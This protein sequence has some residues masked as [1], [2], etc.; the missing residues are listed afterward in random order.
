MTRR[1]LFLWPA[2]ILLMGAMD[3]PPGL[4]FGGFAPAIRAEV[5]AVR[6]SA[7]SVEITW[8]TDLGADSLIVERATPGGLFVPLTRARDSRASLRDTLAA[9]STACFRLASALGDRTPGP[10]TCVEPTPSMVQIEVEP[11]PA[12]A[13]IRWQTAEVVDS[14]AVWRA[15]AAAPR[16]H[17]SARR[18]A[19]VA[20]TDTS[21]LDSTAAAGDDRLEYWVVPFA[22]GHW[23]RPS[24]PVSVS[25]AST[26][27]PEPALNTTLIPPSLLARALPESHS[28]TAHRLPVPQV[29]ARG[30]ARMEVWAETSETLRVERR[31]SGRGAVFSPIGR[32]MPGGILVDEDPL[33]SPELQVEYR[34]A[35]LSEQERA[36]PACPPIRPLHVPP[37]IQSLVSITDRSVRV[38]FRA[39]DPSADSLRLLRRRLPGTGGSAGLAMGTRVQT[40]PQRLSFADL[41]AAPDQPEERIAELDARDTLW[42]DQGLELG[43]RVTYRIESF[44]DGKRLAQAMSPQAVTLM[45]GPPSSLAARIG[46]GSSV[47]LNWRDDCTYET[48]YVVYRDG[49]GGM[50]EAAKLP[51]NASAWVD[52]SLIG[53]GPWRYAVATLAQTGRSARCEAVVVAVDVYPASDLRGRLESIDHVV[54]H[55]TPPKGTITGYEL[56]RRVGLSLPFAAIDTLPP[57]QTSFDDRDFRPGEDHRYRLRTLGLTH[58]SGPSKSWLA[59]LP[60]PFVGGISTHLPSGE[61]AWVARRAVTRAE[62][63]LYAASAAATTPESWGTLWE[64]ATDDDWP[65]TDLSWIEAARYLDWVS[66]LFGLEPYYGGGEGSGHETG[67]VRLPSSALW[68]VAVLGSVAGSARIGTSGAVNEGPGELDDTALFGV[69]STRPAI[70][71]TQGDF[72][73]RNS[74]PVM[75]LRP[76]EGS[77]SESA[78]P[79]LPIREWLNDLWTP[80]G[81]DA[82]ARWRIVAGGGPGGDADT[83]AATALF[84]Y[85]PRIRF[86]DLGFRMA[87]VEP[88]GVTE[89][90]AL[91]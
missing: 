11:G 80:K 82:D 59:R 10:V 50:E 58:R 55:W 2:G 41:L 37:E 45:L 34:L 48:G 31:I 24:L 12:G 29:Q 67:G 52:T 72:L 35:P 1:L 46:T 8:S 87:R 53:E 64:A 23:G 6:L 39:V 56:Q 89:S 26:P 4:E 81:G 43:D 19:R 74:R 15:S 9:A 73:R 49:G 7:D 66:E 18:V 16:T 86:T 78:A 65:A 13:L 90:S 70:M 40:A 36:G 17:A 83:R 21:F 47:T 88:G 79:L 44:R 32:L 76:D 27:T 61:F 28:K 54:L 57:G 22:A 69:R 85:D 25:I 62:F 14:L 91:R 30:T 42:V 77:G 60:S 38:V 71:E 84:P 3:P 68:Q 75:E 20:G 63:R 5:R 51:A 33:L